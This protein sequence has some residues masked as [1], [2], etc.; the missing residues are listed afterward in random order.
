MAQDIDSE[1][2]LTL[3]RGDETAFNRLVERH[4][5]GLV[6]FFYHLCNHNQDVAE[7][8]S[9]EVF[10]RIYVHRA[11]YQPTAKFTTYM[12]KIARHCWIDH[13]RRD[14]RH[15]RMRSLDSV[16]EEDEGGALV[17]GIASTGDTPSDTSDKK[18]FVDIVIK[19]ISALPEDHRMVF[20]LS[21][22]RGMKYPEI[23]QVL[24]VP[25]G[26]VKSRMHNALKKLKEKL[27]TM[28]SMEMYRPIAEKARGGD[29][30]K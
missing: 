5:H 27:G 25:I 26:T 11:T 14:G 6:N 13:L 4:R 18:E 8:L 23:A 19:A 30:G 20:V 24:N 1:L 28:A 21:E 7:D 3:S 16:M 2:M 17:D 9:Q 15:D 10:V 29:E 22:V 12:Y